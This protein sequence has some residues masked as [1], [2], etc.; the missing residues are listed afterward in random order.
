MVSENHEIYRVIGHPLRDTLLKMLSI[1]ELPFSEIVETLGEKPAKINHHLKTL[2]KA[3]LVE[4][5]ERKTKRRNSPKTFYRA[6]QRGKIVSGVSEIGATF[7]R[8]CFKRNKLP[9]TV[10]EIE[11]ILKAIIQPT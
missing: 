10:K 11:E 1:E 7:L 2:I 8:E 4:R 6:T 9:K 3:G 5:I